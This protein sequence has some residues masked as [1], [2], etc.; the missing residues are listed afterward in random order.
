[1]KKGIIKR[2]YKVITSLDEIDWTNQQVRKA[3][4]KAYT[5]LLAKDR[6]NTKTGK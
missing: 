4:G 1:M 6:T 5:T 2:E 3:L